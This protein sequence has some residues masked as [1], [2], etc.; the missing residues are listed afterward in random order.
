MTIDTPEFLAM[1][2]EWDETKTRIAAVA[3]DVENEMKLRKQIFALAFPTPKEG[4]NT[5]DLPGNW[6]I[7]GTYK[8]D[9]KVDEAALPAVQAQLREQGI[10][11]DPLIKFKPEVVTKDYR[12]LTEDARKIFDQAITTKPASPT[13]ELVAP[14]PAT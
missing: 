2:K 4:V 8:L 7:K 5:A 1:L 13:V 12:A 14:K 10:N 6:K 3:I 9:R 11:P